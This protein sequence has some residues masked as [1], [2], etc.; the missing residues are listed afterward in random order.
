MPEAHI[1]TEL[2]VSPEFLERLDRLAAA[3]EDFTAAILP[4]EVSVETPCGLPIFQTGR[5]ADAVP[6]V[7]TRPAGHAP[8]HVAHDEDGNVIVCQLGR[9]PVTPEGWICP[10][11]GETAEA[12]S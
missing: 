4:V 2:T 3:F 6:V 1:T 11:C 9:P 8:G 5:P 7:C 10:A 12:S